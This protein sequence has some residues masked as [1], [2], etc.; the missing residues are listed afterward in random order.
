MNMTYVVGI[1]SVLC[2]AQAA[3]L[4]KVLRVLSVVDQAEDRLAHFSGALAL[5]TE[6]TEEGF[7]AMALEVA[8]RGPAARPRSDET[9][10]LVAEP[11]PAPRVTTSRV[12]RAVRSGRSVPEIA[13]DEEVSE[14]EVRLRLSL[15]ADTAP[16]PRSRAKKQTEDRNGALHA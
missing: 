4:F 3:L 12:V 2:V 11:G 6:T 10:R 9:H 7:R 15:A 5:L 14:G 1:L 13:A 8:R 16:R